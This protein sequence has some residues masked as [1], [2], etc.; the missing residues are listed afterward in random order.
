MRYTA[1]VCLALAA[2]LTAACSA[3]AQ[4]RT[5]L[6][7]D[8][9]DYG[10]FAGLDMR[11]GDIAG[12]YAGLAGA[13]AA[14]RLK[15]NIYLG[16]RGIGLATDA[17]RLAAAAGA[18]DAELEFGYG[19]LLVGYILPLPGALQLTAEALIGAGGVKLDDDTSED[20][21]ERDEVF[22]FEPSLGA[23]IRLASFARIG[24]GA[25]YRYVGGTDVA[26]LRD[27]DLRGVVGT[28]TLRI[29]RF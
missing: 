9:S 20:G 14:V 5:A 7:S 10:I 21:D 24:L 15:E 6:S 26:G 17:E 8:L 3:Q 11:F 22:V 2:A 4:E 19:G 1:I 25:G 16:L 18:P 23:E 12:E 28:A 29:G 13:H 27:H